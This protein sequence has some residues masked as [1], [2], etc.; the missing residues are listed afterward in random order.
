MRLA[1]RG[2]VLLSV[3][4]VLLTPTFAPAEEETVPLTGIVLDPYSEP[5]VGA[6]VRVIVYTEE[7]EKGKRQKREGPFTV[8]AG[9]DGRFEWS[10]PTGVEYR[11]RV[12]AEGFAP[13][14]SEENVPGPD[15]VV[16][17]VPG[18][19]VEGRV[20]AKETG[21]PLEGVRVTVHDPYASWFGKDAAPRTVTG[22]EG[23]YRFANV[24]AGWARL[25]AAHPAHTRASEDIEIPEDRSLDQGPF[26][27]PEMFLGPGGRIAGVATDSGDAPL[28]KV[29]ISLRPVDMSRGINRRAFDALRARTDADGA[30]EI[31][32]VPAGSRY[33]L[34]ANH[35]DFA[36]ASE[37]PFTI[38]AGTDIG[39][40]KIV[41]TTGASLSFRLETP[42]GE[43][44]GEVGVD[45]DPPGEQ[46]FGAILGGGGQYV[47]DKK[48]EVDDEGVR[49]AR[50]LQPGTFKVEIV[51]DG[52]ES[53]VREEIRLRE[54]ETTDLGTFS[55]T[56][57]HTLSGTITDSE[58]EPVKDAQIVASWRK[59]SDYKRRR[60]TSAEDGTF[61]LAGLWEGTTGS[62]EVE[63]K[64]F[65]PFEDGGIE[66]DQD[67][68]E[69]VL[70]RPGRILG[71]V[72]L[73]DGGLPEKFSVKAFEEAGGNSP[74]AAFMP[75]RDAA[76]SRDIDVEKGTFVLEKLDAGKFTVEVRARGRAPARKAGVEVRVD[77]TSD[78]G[79]LVLEPGITLT[80]RVVEEDGDAPIAGAAV[81]L[82]RPGPFGAIA[83][84]MGENP[85]ATAAD[86]EGN[87][88][89]DSLEPG[90]FT[91]RAD[92]PS[93]SPGARDVQLSRESPPDEVVVRL[94]RGGEIRGTVR[95]SSGMPVPK[96]S[97]MTMRGFAEDQ[98]MASTAEDG[99]YGFD[100]LAPGTYMV[101]R[102][103]G[104][105]A[106]PMNM[107]T[108]NATVT[109][110][111]ITIV[112]FDEQPAI[113]LRGRVL[114]GESPVPG[115][116]LMF[117]GMGSTGS[118]PRIK[119]TQSGDDGSYRIG[120]DEAGRYMVT[121]AGGR[122]G[123]S[124]PRGTVEIDVP[125]ESDVTRDIVLG[126]AGIAGRVVDAEGEPVGG[127]SVS[128]VAEGA[129]F[130]LL[131][132]G[133]SGVTAADGSYT[134]AGLEPG[135]Y[136]VLV[137]AEEYA[138]SQ[139]T[140]VSV[141]VGE[142]TGGVDFTLER[143]RAL[144]GRVVDPQGRPVVGAMVFATP[145][146]AGIQQ[147]SNPAATDLNGAFEIALGA[148]SAF[149]IVAVAQG[150]APGKVAAASGDETSELV[151]QLSPG[152][153]VN[154]R[155]VGADGSPKAGVA[156]MAKPV[157]LGPQTALGGGMVLPPTSNASGSAL[158]TGL[159]PGSYEIVCPWR[160]DLPGVPVEVREG[161]ESVVEM[162]VPD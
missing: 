139:R 146:G 58:G 90:S 148:D 10:E 98:R 87:F 14:N 138:P 150:W 33:A 128:A 161:E 94:S 120:L 135:T 51:P 127:A 129:G 56:R 23:T 110:G 62:L 69:I 9:E 25:S 124:G 99:T 41:L 64:G 65:S 43:D 74:M 132:R 95:D 11:V 70:Q 24:A 162:V 52:W 32:G 53:V 136:S 17:L 149:D 28:E 143:G 86:A 50:C 26:P 67:G 63:A 131:G 111:E 102:H 20:L 18:H 81:S 72:V 114:S 134:V 76:G 113:V 22:P 75:R 97:I 84:N 142:V 117:L 158:L 59:E 109:A 7:A 108:K 88:V 12:E 39:S 46:S 68:Y 125:L 119:S 35:E 37:G 1:A 155:V 71:S 153:R 89:L 103:R 156:V 83:A 121:V 44:T 40:L 15:L 106:N 107:E 31:L 101:V 122:G 4:A 34:Q 130:D 126:T 47:G 6:V 16:V 137:N 96:A 145:A 2:F 79:E 45:L 13:W 133:G 60:T 82:T 21:G 48:I 115:A 29:R 91:V 57:G 5:V 80:G 30:F 105:P 159:A 66:S 160:D 147:A 8:K 141:A 140:A 36:P 55:L 19:A 154:V 93:Y 152:G 112:D 73:S 123:A 77:E 61:L 92:H 85:D 118:I 144:R 78:A 54:G 151:V 42:A 3:L 116:N 100:R 104:G 49:T 27:V 38:E 157:N